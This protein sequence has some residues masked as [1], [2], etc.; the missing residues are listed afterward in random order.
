MSE[1]DTK[2]VLATDFR[3]LVNQ[4]YQNP[5]KIRGDTLNLASHIEIILAETSKNLKF[6]ENYPEPAQKRVCA[7]LPETL[8]KIPGS[9]KSWAKLIKKFE[10]QF[11]WKQNES[12]RGIY[13]DTFYDKYACVELIGP[14]AMLISDEIRAGFLL[15]DGGLCYPEHNHEA[16]EIY[17]V[18][19]VGDSSWQKGEGTDFVEMDAGDGVFHETFES[20]AMRT[21][22]EPMIALY[23][24]TGF[25]AKDDGFARPLE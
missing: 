19:N 1:N 12:Y 8:S 4:I 7:V 25:G 13:P 17:H 3:Q 16:L 2:L 21:G 14:N 22:E 5:T 6:N 11:A 10:P 24:W 15:L 18:L 23:T 20:H 9:L